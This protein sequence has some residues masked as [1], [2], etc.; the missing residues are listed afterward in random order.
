MSEKKP[1]TW[2]YP[3][4]G[5]DCPVCGKRTFSQG[6]IHPQCAV[7]QADA[8]RSEK[9]KADRKREAKVAKPSTNWSK[10]K[11]PNCG[12]ESHVRCKSCGCGYAFT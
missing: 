8:A 5:T 10:K 4:R 11:C 7:L 9:L 2:T 6:G 3:R 1:T 12:R